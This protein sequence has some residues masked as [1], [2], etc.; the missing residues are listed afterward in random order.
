[1]L[2]QLLKKVVWEWWS[3]WKWRVRNLCWESDAIVNTNNYALMRLTFTFHR[4]EKLLTYFWEEWEKWW[5]ASRWSVCSRWATYAIR[6]NDISGRIL[7]SGK[8][9]LLCVYLGRRHEKW[10]HNTKELSLREET[11]WR[12]HDSFNQIYEG[13]SQRRRIWGEMEK[14]G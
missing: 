4:I 10:V 6:S 11:I 1:M 8:D 13:L 7:S 14:N 5:Y 2:P 3:G 9:R 12:A